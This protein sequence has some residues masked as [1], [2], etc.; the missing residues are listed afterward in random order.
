VRALGVAYQVPD[1]LPALL[2]LGC[3]SAAVAGRALVRIT[4]DWIEELCLYVA[5]VLP[6]GERKSPVV[7]EVVG[8]LELWERATLA[9]ERD[10]IGFLEQ[11]R[12]LLEARLGQRRDAAARE[13][14]EVDRAAAEAE[15]R[16]LA[17][18]LDA[19][20]PAV[21]PRLL[22]DDATPEALLSVMAEQGGRIAVIGAEGG[23]I[24][25]LAGRYSDG[26]PNLDGVLK[27][28][29]GEP[30]R[31]DRKSRPP[32]HIAR[33]ALALA[34]AVQ[35]AVLESLAA[36][37]ALRGRGLLARILYAVPRTALGHRDLDPPPVPEQVRADYRA[38]LTEVLKGA[39]ETAQTAKTGPVPDYAD[40]AA[41]AAGL[42]RPELCLNQDA[43]TDLRAFRAHLEPRLDPDAG[44]LHGAADWAGKLPG[45]VVR[46]A[47]LLHIYLN[48]W[49]NGTTT[50]IAGET[51][52]SAVAIGKYLIPHALIAL[53][54][55]GPRGSNAAPA[56]ILLG[57]IRREKKTAFK[58]SDALT[59][60][61]RST[62]PDMPAVD[63][64]IRVLEAHGYLRHRPSQ[65]R[66][67]GRPPSPM[68]DVNPLTHQTP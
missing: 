3:I 17:T 50:A 13:K 14:S 6:S 32:E 63:A 29:G 49:S 44:D 38:R 9:S 43:Q 57:W 60:L 65:P 33:P 16:A 2:T 54:M 46:I 1:D 20:E 31:I 39:A 30:I 55:T 68:Y 12:K 5:C 35:P 62:F 64:A 45:S 10:R 61:S 22:A 25:T 40:Y 23:L 11:K 4:P 8:P 37:P 19:L 66:R 42:D 15:V 51:M 67:R 59:A 48:G 36:R 47:A 58:A 18:Q 26:L 21:Y 53:G 28:Y 41:L 24:D 34:L 56:R 27:A 7:R 52:A